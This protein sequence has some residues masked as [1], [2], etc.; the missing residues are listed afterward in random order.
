[1]VVVEMV[2]ASYAISVAGTDGL[3]SQEMN[4]VRRD[5]EVLVLG[6]KVPWTAK[7]QFYTTMCVKLL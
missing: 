7:H 4:R 5:P 2:L 6:T 3:Q 1:M